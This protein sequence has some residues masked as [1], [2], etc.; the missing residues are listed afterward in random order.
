MISI[1][2]TGGSCWPAPAVNGLSTNSQKLA[3]TR[4]ETNGTID[5]SFGDGISGTGSSTT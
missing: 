1:M 2:P 3:V 5:T 4:L